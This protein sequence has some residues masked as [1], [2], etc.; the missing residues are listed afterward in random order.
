MGKGAWVNVHLSKT[1]SKFIYEHTVQLRA[2]FAIIA[3][4][5]GTKNVSSM[6]KTLFERLKEFY[7]NLTKKFFNQLEFDK[8]LANTQTDFERI[9]IA[10]KNQFYE[11]ARA[12]KNLIGADLQIKSQS[13]KFL[14]KKHDAFK[15]R[16][17][18]KIQKK[19]NIDTFRA[20]RETFIC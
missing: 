12:L 19:H 7:D 9:I 6:F 14:N 10:V 18:M 8:I 4:V 2:K 20:M 11:Q 15:T 16:L 13:D 1:Y 5:Y 17:L 3:S